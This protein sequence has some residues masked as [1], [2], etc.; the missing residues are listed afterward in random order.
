LAEGPRLYARL[1]GI[2][3]PKIGDAA[4]LEIERWPSGRCFPTFRLQPT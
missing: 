2:G 1:V 3:E 4:R